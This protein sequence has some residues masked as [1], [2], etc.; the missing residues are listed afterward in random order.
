MEHKTVSNKREITESS[1]RT[2]SAMFD[3][4]PA[5]LLLVVDVAGGGVEL[6]VAERE[7]NLLGEY[8][9]VVAYFCSDAMYFVRL[10]MRNCIK[11]S[12]VVPI[13][14]KIGPQTGI[15]FEPWLGVSK[16]PL[17]VWDTWFSGNLPLFFAASCVKSEGT[18]LRPNLWHCGQL[19]LAYANQIAQATSPI[20]GGLI[21]PSPVS[22]SCGLDIPPGLSPVDHDQRNTECRLQHKPA[23]ARVCRHKR[24]LWFGVHQRI[25]RRSI[26]RKLFARSHVG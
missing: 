5:K 22:P 21:C 6:V 26:P 8:M 18:G 23:L 4:L 3:R 14:A 11:P 16:S 24:L 7:L 12:L 17:I 10:R 15:S 9:G 1:L 25:A 2:Y 19:H 13:E 20:T